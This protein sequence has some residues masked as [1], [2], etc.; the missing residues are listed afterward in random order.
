MKKIL[1]ALVTMMS[2]NLH[3][4]T[5]GDQM[6]QTV[7]CSLAEN[8]PDMMVSVKVF[9]GGLA[10]IPQLQVINY[11][12]GRPTSMQTYLAQKSFAQDINGTKLNIFSG[13]DV[14]L[15]INLNQFVPRKGYMSELVVFNGS[16]NWSRKFIC[17]YTNK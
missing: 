17:S 1:L 11:H 4:Y 7:T 13:Q 3:A 10:G 15:K 2:L 8:I 12:W 16:Y 9:E 14:K 5:G 6:T